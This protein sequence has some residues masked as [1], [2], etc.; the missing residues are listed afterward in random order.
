MQ[1]GGFVGMQF[2]ACDHEVVPS[3]EELGAEV[4]AACAYI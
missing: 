4:S 3:P 1:C 2:T